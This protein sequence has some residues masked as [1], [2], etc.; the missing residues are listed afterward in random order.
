MLATMKQIGRERG[1]DHLIAMQDYCRWRNAEGYPYDPWLRVHVRAGGNVL[2]PCMRSMEV[3]GSRQRWIEWTG[4][5]FP[6][7]GSY[8]L[9]NALVPVTLNGS[10]GWYVEPGIWVLHRLR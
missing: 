10:D 1:F 2:H 8:V 5:E 7:D 9:P 3:K 4:M 6:G